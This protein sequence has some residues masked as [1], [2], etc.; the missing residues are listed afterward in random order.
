MMRMPAPAALYAL[1]QPTAARFIRGRFAHV[2]YAAAPPGSPNPAPER[3]TT[4]A[5]DARVC[6]SDGKQAAAVCKRAARGV[7]LGAPSLPRALEAASPDMPLVVICASSSAPPHRASVAQRQPQSAGEPV[8]LAAA[9]FGASLKPDSGLVWH[10][11]HEPVECQQNALDPLSC[12]P[13][14]RSRAAQCRHPI[15]S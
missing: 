15:C 14:G 11:T 2:P 5:C 10:G 4:G 8:P 3:A 9:A 13:C 12:V 6:G 1:P 7:L